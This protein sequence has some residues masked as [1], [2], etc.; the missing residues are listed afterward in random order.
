MVILAVVRICRSGREAPRVKVIPRRLV[1]IMG[2]PLN[3]ILNLSESQVK[4]S[5][6]EL[7]MLY[8]KAGQTFIDRWLEYSEDERRAG[9]PGATS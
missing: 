4:D 9:A 6:I 5:K 8:G 1:G 3:S 2:I 7:N